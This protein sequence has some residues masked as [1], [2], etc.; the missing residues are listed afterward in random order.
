VGPEKLPAVIL[1]QTSAG[2]QGIGGVIE[3]WSKELNELG[4]ATFAVDSFSRRGI[5]ETPDDR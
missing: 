2:L 5:V 4:T 3:E 1:L